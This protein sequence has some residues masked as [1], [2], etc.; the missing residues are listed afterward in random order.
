MPLPFPINWKN[1]DYV[2][3]FEWRLERL[4]RIRAK[5]EC[6]P[7]LRAFYAD[8]PAQFII[9]WGMT[10]DPRLAADKRPSWMPFLLF[11]KQEE[12]VHWFLERWKNK[13]PGITEKSRDMGMSWLTIGTA[14]ALCTNRPGLVFGFGSRK[15]DYVDKLGDPKS[16]FWKAREFIG[17]LPVE[18]RAGWTL[19][20]HAPHMR[21]IF[22]DT[23]SAM[24]GEAGDNIGRGDRTSAH[25]IDEAAHLERP[26]LVDAAL[27]QTTNCRM[28]LSSV[29]GMANPFAVKRFGGKLH[30]FSFHWRD[31]PRKDDAWYAKQQHDLDPVTVAQEIDIN[32]N[33]SAEG[34][35]IPSEWVQAAVDAHLKLGIRPTG[36]RFAALDVADEGTDKLGYCGAHGIVIERVE[37]WSGVGG[38]IFKSVER[39]FTLCDMHSFPLLR[40]DADGLGAGVRG[41]ARVINERRVKAGSTA[42]EVEAYR[43]SEGVINPTGQDVKGRVNVDFFE[44]RKAQAWWS[45][46]TRFQATYR[47]VV[48]G[49]PFNPDELVSISSTCGNLQ[50]L[51]M[52]LSQATWGESK[53]G[54]ILIEKQ[55]DGTKSPNLADAVVIRFAQ[56]SR[57]AMRIN[58]AA[59][60]R[61]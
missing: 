43:G 18:F 36:K 49:H 20:K 8:D 50:K 5:P 30:V 48:E 21:M 3:V 6:L 1:P 54:K 14:V 15:E 57:A 26:G 9:D 42:L 52:E 12:W 60:A 46:R 19:A 11:P 41:D 39:A 40:Y 51:T 13:E 35:V 24:T 44:N 37:E 16:L 7:A 17:A 4:Q 28:D 10:F 22:P 29:K 33:A 53:V 32:Y 47:A 59:V 2:Q 31:D 27:S 56:S 34:I 25:F 58:P 45:L 23:G 55:P 61:A 38:D